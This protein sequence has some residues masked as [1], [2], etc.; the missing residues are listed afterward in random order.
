MLP[1]SPEA[2]ARYKNPDDDPRGL[3][4]S[5][6]ATAQSGHGTE[7]QFYVLT[8]PNGTK[9]ELPSGRCWVYTKDVMDKAIGEGRI[10]F[11]KDGYGVPRIKTYLDSKDRGLVPE[12]IWFA[13]EASTNERAKNDLKQLF[14]G[15]AVFDTPKPVELVTLMLRVA[16][17]DGIVLDFFAGAGTTAHAVLDLNKQDGGNRKFILVQLPEPT[18]REDYPTIAEITKER[19]RR[20]IKNLNVEDEGKLEL[21]T[22]P[23]PDLGF[24]VF[25]LAES[26]FTTWDAQV[27]SPAELAGQLAAHVEHLRAGRS[28]QDLLA[29]ILLKDGIPLTSPVEVVELGDVTVHSA[30]A[31]KRLICLSRALTLEALR[32]MAD[33]S[34]ER[35]VCLDAGF[36]GNDQLKANA[37]QLFKAK[38]IVFRTA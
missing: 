4:K 28:D 15:D 18:E 11:G 22:G 30:E 37:V 19:V 23:G 5:D 7:S 1:M 25:K 3:W 20:V 34:P 14:G 2:I 31:G 27:A 10:W 32:A 9:H 8:A 16:A 13:T 29:E 21:E 12:S 24:K 38:N 36:Q 35:V 26:N 6:P 33:R 17:S